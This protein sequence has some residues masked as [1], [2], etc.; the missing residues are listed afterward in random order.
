MARESYEA[1]ALS[2]NELRRIVKNPALSSEQK[3]IAIAAMIDSEEESQAFLQSRLDDLN[4]LSQNIS[5]KET[6]YDILERQAK[7]VQRKLNPVVIHLNFDETHSDKDLM[8]AINHF[9]SKEGS[10]DKKAPQ[11]FLTKEEQDKLYGQNSK[12]RVSLYKMLL[13]RHLFY[14][15]KAGKLNLD[16]SY[17]FKSF[18]HYLIPL[19]LW[20]T[21]RK[22]LLERASLTDM[23]NF[24][25]MLTFIQKQ[26]GGAYEQTNER[27]LEQAN[28]HIN[29]R[30]D[31]SYSVNTPKLDEVDKDK[32]A[33]FFPKEEY[34]PLLEVLTTIDSTTNFLDCF[35]PWKEK[36]EKVRPERSSFLASIIG[37][38]CNIGIHKMEKI[39][40]NRAKGRLTNVVNWYFSQENI[41]DANSRIV[42]FMNAMELPNVY[43]DN[44]SELH[45]SSDG[46]KV[47][48]AVDSLLASHSFKYFGKGKGVSVY[49]FIDQRNFNFYSMVNSPAD[50]ESTFVFDGLVHNDNIKSTMHSTD[51]H[52]Q[53]EA[54][55][56]LAYLLGFKL[57]PRIS[58]LSDCTLYSLEKKEVYIDRDYKI[59]PTKYIN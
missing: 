27:I 25:D 20:K 49:G 59:L 55:F 53:S 40:R 45:T 11:A 30:K 6:T 42:D 2:K 54:A 57:A 50:R 12:F 38:G 56:A 58:K 14:G 17:K 37:Y 44:E 24:G 41:D 1:N 29:F 9:K 33:V 46:Q 35:Q 32:L 8:E 22:Q 13:F 19:E 34:V 48:V 31:G 15:I 52:G 39:S 7:S 21:Q 28:K 10:I 26:L 51:T 23:A 5:H 3:V 18:S 16:D 4:A 36:Y 47:S 43:L